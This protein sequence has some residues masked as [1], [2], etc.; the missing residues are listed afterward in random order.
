MKDETFGQK[1]LKWLKWFFFSYIWLAVLLFVVDL[2]TKLVVVKHFGSPDVADGNEIVV[3]PNFVRITYTVNWHAAMGLGFDNS[4][5]NRILY[6]VIAF[7]G[8]GLILGFYIW[9]FKKINA[10]VKACLMLMAVGALGNLIDRL[11]Y[12]P[13]FLGFDV[14][15]VVDWIDF[16]FNHN[17]WGYVFNIADSC[18]V[19]G[20][21]MLI[22]FL[23]VDEVKEYRKKKQQEVKE[24]AGKVL[25]KEEQSRLENESKPEVVEEK[26][27][28]AQEA[29][30]EE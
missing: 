7:I 22:V 24:P 29:P 28:D 5:V 12:T 16:Y 9:K 3:I 8:L 10:L 21:L 2:V 15:G 18:V 17:V 20:T 1:L 30:K 25:S 4:L 11:F 23:I 26:N 13:Q 14:N 6:I 27:N 19:I